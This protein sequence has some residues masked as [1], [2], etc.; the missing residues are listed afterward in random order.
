MSGQ[1]PSMRHCNSRVHI[2]PFDVIEIIFGYF[3][4]PLDFPMV[5]LMRSAYGDKCHDGGS[6]EPDQTKFK[7]Y[8]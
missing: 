1:L 2:L 6:Y 7:W 3:V 8:R 4:A 5:P